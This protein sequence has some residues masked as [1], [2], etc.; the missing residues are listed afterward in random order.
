MRDRLTKEER[1]IVKN[2]RIFIIDGNGVL[3]NSFS[4]ATLKRPTN[5][6]N[7]LLRTYCNDLGFPRPRGL[8]LSTWMERGIYIYPLRKK[9]PAFRLIRAVSIMRKRRVFLL[10]GKQAISW[11]H[12]WIEKDQGHLIIC[13]SY[14]GTTP[15]RKHFMKQKPFSFVADWLGV[16]REIWRQ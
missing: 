7:A 10:L 3:S 5:A 11:C 12:K 13:M 16:S 15:Q 1:K 9:L 2:Y 8:N 4:A 6:G 14:P